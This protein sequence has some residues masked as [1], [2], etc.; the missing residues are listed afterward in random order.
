MQAT[1]QG[2][3]KRST[4]ATA[5]SCSAARR[6]CRATPRWRTRRRA[7]AA[8]APPRRRRPRPRRP[9]PPPGPTSA[10]LTPPRPAPALA[11]GNPASEVTPATRTRKPANLA[12]GGNLVFPVPNSGRRT[13]VAGH[14]RRVTGA[15]RPT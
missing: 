11:R 1:F 13:T 4:D 3:P 7:S 15:P 2:Q 10:G 14:P 12:P 6:C 9:R 8:A 5:G